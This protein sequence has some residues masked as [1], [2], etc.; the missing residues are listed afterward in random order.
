[1]ADILQ[2]TSSKDSLYQTTFRYVPVIRI[3]HLKISRPRKDGHRVADDIFICILLN[4]M[5]LL[6]KCRFI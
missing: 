5:Y 3:S 1:M 4:E 6:C 2:A